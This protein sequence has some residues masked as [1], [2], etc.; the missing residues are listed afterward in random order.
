M[1]RRGEGTRERLIDVAE[2][3]FAERGVASVSL[4]EIRLAAG[5]RNSSALQFHFGDRDGLLRAIAERHLPRLR[6]IQ[7][8]IAHRFGDA[9]EH[10]P[11]AL[12]EILLRPN[13]EYVFAGSS[14]RAWTRISAELAGHPDVAV[15]DF[16]ASA[17]RVAT[18]AG[19]ALLE[20]LS[21]HMPSEVALERLLTVSLASLH[22]C[23]D[24]ARAEEAQRSGRVLLAKDA[25]VDNLV[26]MAVG[27]LFAPAR[28]GSSA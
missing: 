20:A 28:A 1:T 15:T 19:A 24:R 11:R 9:D 12:V 16:A 27:A 10:D 4:R 22:V 13:A 8:T 6:A 18:R 3:L 2:R 25:F 14:A 7:E 17:P 26:D 21:A 5:Q 23:A